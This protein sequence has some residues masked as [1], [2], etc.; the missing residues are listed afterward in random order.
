M[1]E[2]SEYNTEDFYGEF[3][4]T[5]QDSN[6]MEWDPTMIHIR[7]NHVI[8]HRNDNEE[9]KTTFEEKYYYPKFCTE[10]DFSTDYEKKWF[11]MVGGNNSKFYCF[12]NAEYYL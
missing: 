11:E 10:D 4:F 6:K 9:E 12:N 8:I 5:I 3:G 2:I 1:F 7:L